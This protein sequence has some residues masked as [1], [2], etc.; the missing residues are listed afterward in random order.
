MTQANATFKMRIS[1]D[2]RDQVIADLQDRLAALENSRSIPADMNFT[3]GAAYYRRL[4]DTPA[5]Q[6]SE[7]ERIALQSF[8]EALGAQPPS[9]VSIKSS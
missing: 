5:G 3:G 1:E 7:R 6:L 8:L 9:G 2:S 4:A